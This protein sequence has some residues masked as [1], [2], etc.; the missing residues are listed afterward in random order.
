MIIRERLRRAHAH[1]DSAS[2]LRACLMRAAAIVACV[3]ISAPLAVAQL[4]TP[5]LPGTPGE[6]TDDGCCTDTRDPP[7]A[8]HL[9]DLAGD[10]SLYPPADRPGKEYIFN[11][12]SNVE[13]VPVICEE[14]DVIGYNAMEYDQNTR[15]RSSLPSALFEIAATGRA[16]RA[17]LSPRPARACAT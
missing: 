11:L 9:K 13:K 8:W 14:D 6:C 3:L 12:L 4:P 1:L 2:A 10:R 17:A 5:C 16:R 15:A 7:V